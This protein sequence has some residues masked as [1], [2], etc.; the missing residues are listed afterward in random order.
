MVRLNRA[1]LA[2]LVL[3][4]VFASVS[5]VV[6][7]SGSGSVVAG[8]DSPTDDFTYTGESNTG[9]LDSDDDVNEDPLDEEY[10]DS[11]GSGDGVGGFSVS[12]SD[13]ATAN[14]LSVLPLALVSTVVLRVKN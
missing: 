3:L 7:D 5:S 13:H 4:V 6:A 1:L 9:S 8:D 11:N 2:L 12:L 14:P 10:Y